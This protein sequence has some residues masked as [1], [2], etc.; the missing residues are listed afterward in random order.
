MIQSVS[1]PKS[2]GIPGKKENRLNHASC[3]IW[4]TGKKSQVSDRQDL[5]AEIRC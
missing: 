3:A 2:A 5:V 1:S 4:W